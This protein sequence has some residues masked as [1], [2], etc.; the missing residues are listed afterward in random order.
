MHG[1]WY[2]LLIEYLFQ[3]LKLNAD[4]IFIGHKCFYR[5][6]SPHTGIHNINSKD[7]PRVT[8]FMSNQ[9]ANMK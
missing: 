6:F 3:G 8:Q 1:A 5:T 4:I 2:Y 7:T 9:H